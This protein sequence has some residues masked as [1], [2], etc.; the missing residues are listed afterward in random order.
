MLSKY[1]NKKEEIALK[2][3]EQT[4]SISDIIQKLG[5]TSSATLYRWN[6]HQKAELKNWHG[7]FGQLENDVN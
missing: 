5:Y 1:T 7:S 3:F 4:G 2:E 6:D